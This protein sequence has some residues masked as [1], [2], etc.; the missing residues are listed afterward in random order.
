MPSN[1]WQN[2][3][4]LLSIFFLIIL[5][6]LTRLAKGPSINY[7]TQSRPLFDLPN[8]I[9]FWLFIL[10]STAKVISEFCEGELLGEL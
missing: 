4:P 3:K 5:W 7:V 6:D 9:F 10:A 8:P 1:T 2:L